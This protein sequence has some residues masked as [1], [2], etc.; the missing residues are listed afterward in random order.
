[1]YSPEVSL[2]FVLIFFLCSMGRNSINSIKNSMKSTHCSGSI[3]CLNNKKEQSRDCGCMWGGWVLRG[4]VVPAPMCKRPLV[5]VG[6][7]LLLLMDYKCLPK[8]TNGVLGGGNWWQSLLCLSS[9]GCHAV[10]WW[11]A[12]DFHWLVEQPTAALFF[13]E[14]H[15]RNTKV[16]DVSCVSGIYITLDRCLWKEHSV[17]GLITSE[18][19][20]SLGVLLTPRISSDS[21]GF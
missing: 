5:V 6:L 4:L 20:W 13:S 21:P 3:L 1:M 19:L 7:V 18:T 15:D 2:H 8:E 9:P 16:E 17:S 14:L 10:P 12:T 11:R